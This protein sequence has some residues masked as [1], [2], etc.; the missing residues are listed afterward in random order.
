MTPPEQIPVHVPDTT[1]ALK[2]STDLEWRA[3][4]A[5]SGPVEGVYNPELYR[6]MARAYESGAA[7][8]ANAIER[9]L[10][11]KFGQNLN[12]VH[13]RR[14]I[15]EVQAAL[16]RE[17]A[18]IKPKLKD[19]ECDLLCKE[20][21]DGGRGNPAPCE[22][23]ALIYFTE[24][25]D[26]KDSLAWN[27]FTSEHAVLRNLP[28]PV[29]AKAG[30]ALKDHHDT[31]F[32]VWLQTESREPKWNIDTVRRS[33][34]C[35][36]KVR[37]FN[38]V[39][40]YLNA[41]P[42]WDGVPRLAGWLERYCG[43]GNGESDDS[44]EATELGQF[45]SAIGERWWISLIARAFRPG[46]KV[47]HVLVLEGAKGIGKTTLAEIIFG[48]HYAVIVGDVTSKDNQALMSA[49]LWGVLM[50]ELDVLG[51]SAMRAIKSWVTRDFE[52]FRPTWG[53][54]HEKRLRQCVF[55]ATVNGTDWALEED[56][57]WWPVSCHKAFDLDGLRADR[58]LLMAEALAKFRAGARWHFDAEEDAAL[59]VTAKHEQSARV[60][61]DAWNG[62]VERT[63]D[64]IMVLKQKQR[65]GKRLGWF[66]A[67]DE[68]V[69]ALP[70]PYANDRDKAANRVGHN[71][72]MLGWERIQVLIEE[73][74]R[75]VIRW[76]YW[77]PRYE[78]RGE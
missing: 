55:I 35:A 41:L 74:G 52:K 23:N 18:A 11:A 27:E 17:G 36:A 62:L 4:S 71:L 30:E 38:P 20:T 51:R 12:L 9:K 48:E 59:I 1:P 16:I 69:D 72:K 73:D 61:E 22:K 40:D 57:R 77:N 3:A 44:Q 45:I 14:E 15:K 8:Q 31:L 24:H 33:V 65:I 60:P 70:I 26:W 56:R 46:C 76:R 43:A 42:A 68:V 64:K 67:K 2:I 32:S 13:F 58:D 78:P 39:K 21:K 63:L 19:W 7:A 34:D 54:R 53:H 66:V 75:K 47:H 5:I 6:A 28:D 50:D 25:P 10:R 29:N 37:S 49:G